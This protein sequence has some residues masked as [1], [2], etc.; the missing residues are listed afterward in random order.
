MLLTFK[1]YSSITDADGR[2]T[3][4]LSTEDY[5]FGTYRLWFDIG[6]YYYDSHGVTTFFP[7]VEV[8][9]ENKDG[10]ASHI[11][12]TISPYAMGTYKGS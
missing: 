8:T 3:Q 2:I 9:Y 7:E 10:S 4:F 11:P 5:T 12:L 6:N 1:F